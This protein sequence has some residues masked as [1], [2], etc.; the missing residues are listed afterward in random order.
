[1]P[2]ELSHI[3]TIPQSHNVRKPHSPQ[4]LLHECEIRA[5]GGKIVMRNILP[6]P[7]GDVRKHLPQWRE[8]FSCHKNEQTLRF[9]VYLIWIV[10]DAT[11]NPGLGL[12]I[13]SNLFYWPILCS[14][15]LTHR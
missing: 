4:R 12:G 14:D 10:S 6:K 3:P 5:K 1:M 11:A 15:S 8:Y 7:R 2:G 13:H 9:K